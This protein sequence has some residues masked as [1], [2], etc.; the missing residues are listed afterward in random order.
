MHKCVR[1]GKQANSLKE[2]HEGCSCGSKAFVFHR[3]APAPSEEKK[4][5]PSAPEAKPPQAASESGAPAEETGKAPESSS[6]RTTFSSEDVENIKIVS[7]G[8][9]AVDVN[10]LSKNPVVLKDEEG[11]YYVKIP[12]NPDR[13]DE[14]AGKNNGTNLSGKEKG[15]AAAQQDQKI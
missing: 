1:C 4:A 5:E 11:V 15:Q 14:T 10:A 6:A 13:W 9:F 8:V 7:E 2:I 3:E 12:F